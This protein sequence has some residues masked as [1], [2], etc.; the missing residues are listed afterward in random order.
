MRRGVGLRTYGTPLAVDNGRD[1]LRDALEEAFDLTI[2]L[3][4]AVAE[5]E[6]LRERVAELEA[7]VAELETGREGRPG[8]GVAT[9]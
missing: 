4:A 5:R 6:G 9:P 2:Y 8:R 7:R 1:H 3:R